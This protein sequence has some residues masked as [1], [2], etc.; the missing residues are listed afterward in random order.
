VLQD[1]NPTGDAIIA[2]GSRQLMTR[3]AW[4][5]AAVSVLEWVFTV[6]GIVRTI[7]RRQ[8]GVKEGFRDL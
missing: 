7:R 6:V 2:F 4:A 8:A 3:F 1:F 5:F